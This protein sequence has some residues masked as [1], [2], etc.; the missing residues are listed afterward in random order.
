MALGVIQ[1]AF[2]Q[3]VMTT[4]GHVPQGHEG[5]HPE[6]PHFEEEMAPEEFSLWS[7]EAAELQTQGCGWICV[8]CAGWGGG[9]Q[10]KWG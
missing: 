8:I 4:K 2:P 7:M 10:T 9:N 3:T 6:L 1:Q 5:A